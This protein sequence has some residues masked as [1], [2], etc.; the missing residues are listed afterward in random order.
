MVTAPLPLSPGATIAGRFRL[1]RVIGAGGMGVVWSARD[2]AG[3]IFAIKLVREGGVDP[4]ERERLLREARAAMRIGHPNMVRVLD[5]GESPDVG[6]FVVM[7]LLEGE[8]L[9]AMLTR[10][11]TLTIAECASILGPVSLAIEAAHANNVVHRDLKPENVFLSRHGVK[12]LDF[13]IAKRIH[14]SAGT[15]VHSLTQSGTIVGTP[16]YMS[17]EQVYGDELDGRSDVWSL[18]VVLYECLSG[19]RPIEGESL[20]PL[21]CAITSDPIPPLAHVRPD[22]PRAVTSLVDRMLARR[23][24]DRPSLAE[25]RAELA[26]ATAAAETMRE[27]GTRPMALVRPAA[28]PP[29]PATA[30]AWGLEPTRPLPAPAPAPAGPPPRRIP[31]VIWLAIPLAFVLGVIG[32]GVAAWRLRPAGGVPPSGSGPPVK[33]VSGEILVHSN[34]AQTA[35]TQRNG[36][37]CLKELDALDALTPPASRS[38]SPSSGWAAGRATCMMLA[39]D[40]EAAKAFMRQTSPVSD[41]TVRGSEDTIDAMVQVYCEGTKLSPRDEALVASYRLTMASAGQVR[42]TTAECLRWRDAVVRLDPTIPKRPFGDPLTN[43]TL[44]ANTNVSRCVARAGDCKTAFRV[45]REGMLPS[46]A[47]LD[48]KSREETVRRA[49]DADTLHGSCAGAR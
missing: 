19:A 35:M 8:S 7:E 34:R 30:A 27:A 44:S 48:P 32:T 38:T 47:A 31:I 5:V 25:V 10:R 23:R 43:A 1:E 6:P 39:G 26:G 4:R 46:L 18:G 15:E 49:F 37:E 28:A 13:G 16:S 20:G 45:F 42:A 21:L 12:V 33:D 3:A 2:A 41:P 17:P 14:S 29:P 9:R 11:R 24:E 40:C 36:K 22:L